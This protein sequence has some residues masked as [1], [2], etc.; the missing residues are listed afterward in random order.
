MVLRSRQVTPIWAQQEPD[1]IAS[2]SN[3]VDLE[4]IRELNYGKKPK[5]GAD[6]K[7]GPWE[8]GVGYGHS[9]TEGGATWDVQATEKAQAQVDV[10]MREMIEHVT[11]FTRRGELRA[12][13]VQKSCRKH[14]R[15]ASTSPTP[16]WLR[17]ALVAVPLVA[18]AVR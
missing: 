2:R 12:E 11:D 17:R 15:A 10:E 14:A 13:L 9:G 18:A 4:R 5:P 6:G 16:P 7:K 1:L 3:E 8:S